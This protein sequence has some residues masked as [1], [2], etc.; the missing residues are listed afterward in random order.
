VYWIYLN[1]LF[2]SFPSVEMVPLRTKMLA[3]NLE[4]HNL[5]QSVKLVRGGV[6]HTKGV[7]WVANQDKQGDGLQWYGQQLSDQQGGITNTQVEVHALDDVLKEYDTIDGIDCD[8]QGAEGNVFSEEMF[9]LLNAKVKAI[10]I[11]THGEGVHKL[12]RERFL[13]H[14][15]IIESDFPDDGWSAAARVVC[16]KEPFVGK[17]TQMH[18]EGCVSFGGG[19]L[20]V[21]CDLDL[22]LFFDLDRSLSFL[23]PSH[24][25]VFPSGV[26]STIHKFLQSIRIAESSSKITMNMK[27]DV[28]WTIVIGYKCNVP[29]EMSSS[30]MLCWGTLELHAKK[31]DV[32]GFWR[33]RARAT[34][35]REKSRAIFHK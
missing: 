7:A 17:I 16:Q 35:T 5:T 24:I 26:E 31:W 8:I 19:L 13:K 4:K 18:P 25:G 28:R 9:P 30:A 20:Q 22:I 34:G 14:S 33:G 12:L 27:C 29:L 21:S 3:L 2:T 32:R 10:R 15:W 23:I 6:S 1:W 11:E